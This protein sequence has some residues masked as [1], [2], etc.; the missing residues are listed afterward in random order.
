[1]TGIEVALNFEQTTR[2]KLLM[3]VDCHTHLYSDGT[4]ISPQ[5]HRS[6]CKDLDACIVLAGC[7]G[8]RRSA[9]EALSDYVRQ[10]SK[11]VGFAT[12]NPTEDPVTV[13]QLKKEVLDKDLRGLVLY[14]AEERFHPAHSQA[15]NLYEA[16]AELNL[17]I[18]FHNCPPF[19]QQAVMDY[20]RPF[21]L[22]EIARTFPTLKIVV[23]RM[24]FPFI[25]QT[26]C[27]LGKHENVFADLTIIPQ[28]VWEVYNLVM[29]A[30]EA[31]VMDRLLFG[32]GYPYAL[33]QTCIEALLGFNKMLSDTHLPQVPR[34]KLRSVIERDSLAALGLK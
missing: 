2:E 5:E 6:A 13:R 33:P 23:G 12:I 17:P 19:S 22:D 21:Q 20:A 27:L 29:S 3:I 16:A 11:A 28:K 14:C 9:N 8:D 7:Q 30:Y 10:N 31:G 15:M 26:W 18:F 32:S 1:M 24:G 34:E 25:E 4:R